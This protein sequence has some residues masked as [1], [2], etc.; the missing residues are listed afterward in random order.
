MACKGSLRKK[1][2]RE[3]SQEFLF[4]RIFLSGIL[5]TLGKTA[6]QNWRFCLFT[7][8]VLGWGFESVL[9]REAVHWWQPIPDLQPSRI[10]QTELRPFLSTVPIIVLFDNSGSYIIMPQTRQILTQWYSAIYFFGSSNATPF[11][12]DWQN[13]GSLSLVGFEGSPADV[14]CYRGQRCRLGGSAFGMS[15]GD[16]AIAVPGAK[17]IG[18]ELMGI[19]HII[20]YHGFVWK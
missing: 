16:A 13:A 5:S 11:A 7:V 19:E 12:E 2:Q 6:M 20:K 15:K 17:E 14:R 18:G 1:K 3:N 9:L 8:C 10:L 4:H